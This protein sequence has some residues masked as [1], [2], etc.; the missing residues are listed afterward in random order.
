MTMEQYKKEEAELCRKMVTGPDMRRYVTLGSLCSEASRGNVEKMRK[1]LDEKADPNALDTNPDPPLVWACMS[2]EKP[3]KIEA[4]RMLLEAGAKVA[5][6]RVSYGSSPLMAA[7]ASGSEGGVVLLLEAGAA[8]Q[9]TRKS[10]GKCA[11]ELADENGWEDICQHLRDAKP[12]EKSAALSGGAKSLE[13]WIEYYMQDGEMSR[14]D[15]TDLA[16]MEVELAEPEVEDDSFTTTETGLKYKDFWVGDEDRPHKGDFVH[17]HYTGR[18]ENGTVFDSTDDKPYFKFPIG[19]GQVIAGWDE[20]V[21]T[22]RV[23][24]K[25]QLVIPPGLAY[26]DKGVGN[27]ML[28]G[29]ATLIFDVELVGI[30]SGSRSK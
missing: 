21:A 1:L 8:P 9:V 15:A 19:E 22:M 3:D 24:G 14:E 5:G 17:V 6:D 16:E 7:A 30:T 13:Q 28:P 18:L 4:I 10:D 26:G 2:P 27:G 25:R 23:G 11:A 12:V 29:H 20:G